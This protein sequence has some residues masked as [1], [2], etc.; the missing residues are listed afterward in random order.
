MITLDA[1]D[2]PELPPFPPGQLDTIKAALAPLLAA[3]DETGEHRNAHLALLMT[4]FALEL[5]PEYA[6]REA[7]IVD[8]VTRNRM[9]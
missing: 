7:Q 6:R 8:L 5:P 9:M 3:L 2:L 1:E 4:L